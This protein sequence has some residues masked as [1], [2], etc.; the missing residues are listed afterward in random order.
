MPRNIH[1]PPRNK[2]Y[3]LK[4]T[5]NI[6]D[7]EID[8]EIHYTCCQYGEEVDIEQVIIKTPSGKQVDLKAK[9]WPEIDWDLES[10]MQQGAR[11]YDEGAHGDYL[12][13]Q[14]KDDR[15]ERGL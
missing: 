1:I 13:D 8:A 9:F 2:S 3:S 11:E 5:I 10:R 4:W 14:W 7:A 6:G 12:Y 15:M